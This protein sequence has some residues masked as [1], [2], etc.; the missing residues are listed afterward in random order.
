MS[1]FLLVALRQDLREWAAA[2]LMFRRTLLGRGRVVSIIIR[3]VVT[4]ELG[5]HLVAA[6]TP[7][8]PPMRLRRVQPTVRWANGWHD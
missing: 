2:F 8:H 7:L 3:V 5:R 4:A 1:L 6:N